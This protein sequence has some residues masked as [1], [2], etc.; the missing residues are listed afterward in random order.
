MRNVKFHKVRQ[1]YLVLS[2]CP[3][4]AKRRDREIAPTGNPLKP[5]LNNFGKRNDP[6][7]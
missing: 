6:G 3:A 1:D 5:K 4:Y 2:F 7:I